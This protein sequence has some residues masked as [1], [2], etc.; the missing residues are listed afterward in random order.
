MARSW[1]AG[2]GNSG[3]SFPIPAEP[4]I[5]PGDFGRL[6]RIQMRH[7]RHAQVRRILALALPLALALSAAT[8]LA[9]T[10]Y[11]A[12]RAY[13]QVFVP[14]VP[15]DPVSPFAIT[16]P[17]VAGPATAPSPGLPAMPSIRVASPVAAL[18]LP[19]ATGPATAVAATPP[20][21]WGPSCPAWTVRR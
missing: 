16:A 18:R 11:Q 8:I 2:P 5:L 14:P 21:R 3:R 7:R 13:R 15:H 1:G 6:Q 9:P 20:R 4:P 12:T 10:L 17:P 19:T